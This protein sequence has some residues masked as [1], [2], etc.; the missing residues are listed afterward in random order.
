MADEEKRRKDI[1]HEKAEKERRENER[2]E[3][4]KANLIAASVKA[5]DE[6]NKMGINP[7]T[8]EAYDKNQL[9]LARLRFET[10]QALSANT[11]KMYKFDLQK[12]GLKFFLSD[13]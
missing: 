6:T 5:V 11:L 2:R 13:F 1:E 8:L 9:T 12:V 4:E 7:A 3:N 10:D